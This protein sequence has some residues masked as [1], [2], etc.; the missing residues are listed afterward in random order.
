MNT[1][2]L[3]NELTEITELLMVLSNHDPTNDLIEESYCRCRV[4]RD[5]LEEGRDD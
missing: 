3:F 4:L 5:K 1:N 2:Y